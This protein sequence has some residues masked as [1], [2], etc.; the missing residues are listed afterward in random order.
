MIAVW[1]LPEEL[2]QSEGVGHG[3]G[4][5]AVLLVTSNNYDTVSPLGPG[6][7]SN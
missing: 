5:G 6:S 2:L 3:G 1:P 4:V 7:W